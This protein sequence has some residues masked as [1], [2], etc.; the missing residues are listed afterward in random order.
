[1]LMPFLPKK[2]YPNIEFTIKIDLI[3]SS[4]LLTQIC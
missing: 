1:M 2:Y 3:K 4:V